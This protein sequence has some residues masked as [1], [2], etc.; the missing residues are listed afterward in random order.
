MT[1][2][3]N[4][5]LDTSCIDHILV[6][7]CVFNTITD[8]YVVHDGNNPSN[9]NALY[10]SI[11]NFKDIYYANSDC[12]DRSTKHVCSWER[13]SLNDLVRRC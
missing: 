3:I 9:H 12:F 11:T 5:K 7:N 8:N 10:L 2:E 13:A 4:V 6:D 1:F